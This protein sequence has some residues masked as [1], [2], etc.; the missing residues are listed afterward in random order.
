MGMIRKTLSVGTLGL[1]SFRSKS[2]KLGR[3]EAKLGAM[4]A[5]LDSEHAAREEA[6]SRATAAE[7]QLKAAK[8]EAAAARKQA[9]R[10]RKRSKHSATLAGV[11]DAG[12]K[13]GRKG[14]RAAKHLAE[15]AH[16]VVSDAVDH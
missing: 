4:S 8:H 1:V 9:S 6:E 5:G 10:L 2:E 11:S 7:T 3:S 15:S 14:K 13:L 12:K 16:A